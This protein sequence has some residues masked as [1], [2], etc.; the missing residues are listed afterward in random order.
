MNGPLL[1]SGTLTELQPLGAGGDPVFRSAR[2][3][4]AGIQR[5]LGE[6]V[7]ASF[8]IP[9]ANERGD[10]LD[11]YAPAPGAVTRW[12]ELSD[13][14]RQSVRDEVEQLQAR[15]AAL[16]QSL[17]GQGSLE[18]RA[19][20]SLLEHA[21]TIP[22]VSHVFLVDDRPVL[23]FWGFRR[24]SGDPVSALYIGQ[25]PINPLTAPE[26]PT[27][28]EAG[29][30]AENPARRLVR[31]LPVGAIVVAIAIGLAIPLLDRAG[32]APVALKPVVP[33]ASPTGDRKPL[34]IPPDA[35]KTGSTDFLTGSWRATGEELVDSQTKQ[36][37]V[38]AYELHEGRGEVAVTEQDGSVCRAPVDASF[39]GDI[40]A[41]KPQS[42]IV[43]PNR[44][45]YYGATV[46][47]RPSTDGSADC[48][49]SFPNGQSFRVEILKYR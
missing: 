23:A 46:S 49:G 45:P 4:R 39:D 10:T 11:W 27:R 37:I 3:L 14:R 43:C 34:V 28:T 25:G 42:E 35:V 31:W 13:E 24:R 33:P 22:D 32:K 5:Q 41:L 26:P 36:P 18:L 7:A 29:S 48:V 20:G 21:A 8:A 16:S 17:N 12:A 1:E 9:Q 6:E 30:I 19:F 44:D 38:L 2:E 40:L 47:C 15:I